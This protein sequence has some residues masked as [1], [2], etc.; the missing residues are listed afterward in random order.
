LDLPYSGLR[1]TALE[2]TVT[3]LTARDHRFQEPTHVPKIGKNT[4]SAVDPATAIWED[5]TMP[6]V[7]TADAARRLGVSTTTVIAMIADGRLSGRRGSQPQR[8]RW[9]VETDAA[10]HLLDGARSPIGGTA[11][12]IAGLGPL[13]ARIAALET[14][15]SSASAERYREAALLLND[16]VARQHEA[17]ELQAEAARIL[18]ETVAAQARII[19]TL[20]IPD[21]LPAER[22][23]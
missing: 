3:L 4:T 7:S 19:A 20:L 1:V 16:T 10:G 14:R 23:T 6:W 13:L 22:S 5:K 15:D 12:A 8:A 2:E 17:A 21:V 11:P 9:H 18:S